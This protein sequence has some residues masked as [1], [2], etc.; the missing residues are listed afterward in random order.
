MTCYV[1]FYHTQNPATAVAIR[2][3]LRAKYSGECPIF[4]NADAIT[5]D[6]EPK[7]VVDDLRTI[8]PAGDQ[9]FVIRSGTQAA[10]VGA[11]SAAHDEWLKKNL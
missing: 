9:V 11:Y 4:P 5:T 8:L 3:R 7:A 10:W 2:N 6:L 1:V